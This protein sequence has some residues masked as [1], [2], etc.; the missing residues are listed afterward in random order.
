MFE[1]NTAD[2]YLLPFLSSYTVTVGWIEKYK[3][4]MTTHLLAGI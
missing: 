1:A 2:G 3:L 4:K